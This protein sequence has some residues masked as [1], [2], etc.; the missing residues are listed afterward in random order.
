M[1]AVKK[2]SKEGVGEGEYEDIRDD[3]T[4]KE[5]KARLAADT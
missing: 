5:I 1:Y 4:L 3:S 2:N